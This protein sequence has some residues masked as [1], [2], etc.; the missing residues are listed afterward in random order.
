MAFSF[1][2]VL[3]ALVPVALMGAGA[4][5]LHA[6]RARERRL[7]ALLDL[8]DAVQT[9]LAR[10]SERMTAWRGVVGRLAG[11]LG[12]GAQ[13]AL[14]GEPLIREAKRDLLQHR[15]WIQS[16]GL[17]AS[18]SELSDAYAALKRAHD[19]LAEQL[20]ALESAG[21]A[22]TQATDAA[23]EAARREPASLR[24]PTEDRDPPAQ[25]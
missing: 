1:P 4:L 10:A 13:R 18:K 25:G 3:M 23:H 15:L 24:R 21:D 14:E 7:R 8:A 22:L 19:R 20:S 5:Y 16:S 2:L 6:R 12:S 17:T 11:D 9:L